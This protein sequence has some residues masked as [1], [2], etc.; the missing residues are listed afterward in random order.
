VRSVGGCG[1]ALR[2]R[3]RGGAGGGTAAWEEKRRTRLRSEQRLR[4]R[5]RGVTTT[6]VDGDAGGGV[7]ALVE[8]QLGFKSRWRRRIEKEKRTNKVYG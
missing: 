8:A 3:R 5:R 1:S 4:G 2:G 7:T 6:A